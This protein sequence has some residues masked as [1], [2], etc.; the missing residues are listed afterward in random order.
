MPP[1]LV[2][3]ICKSYVVT[4]IWGAWSALIYVLTDIV[5]EKKHK[6]IT[7]RFILLL[8]ARVTVAEGIETQQEVE[9]MYKE[10][11]DYI[12]GFYYSKPLPVNEFLKFL[13]DKAG[14]RA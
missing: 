9:D 1:L 6:K 7:G 12:Q 4:L 14:L 11:L 5:T 3:F 10:N 8:T 2:E 13:Q